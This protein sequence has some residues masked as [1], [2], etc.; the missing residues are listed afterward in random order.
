M[1]EFEALY[2]PLHAYIRDPK[3]MVEMCTALSSDSKLR[4]FKMAAIKAFIDRF[5]GKN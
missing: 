4:K 1:L 3:K 2:Y 5:R